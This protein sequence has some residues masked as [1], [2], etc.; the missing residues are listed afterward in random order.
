[1]MWYLKTID[2]FHIYFEKFF[3]R[4]NF[5]CHFFALAPGVLP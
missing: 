2:N 4:Q 5:F 3:F 1:M